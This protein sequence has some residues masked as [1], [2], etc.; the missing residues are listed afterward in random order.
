MTPAKPTGLKA[1]IAKTPIV[2]TWARIGKNLSA[3]NATLAA[4]GVAFYA[5]LSIFPAIACLLMIWGFFADVSDLGSSFSILQGTV[6]PPVYEIISEQ[7]MRIAGRDSDISLFA[8][9][10]SSVVALWSASKAINALLLAMQVMYNRKKKR[11]FLMQKLMALGFT[12]GGVVF[13]LA[14]I[15]LIG[16]IPQILEALRLG[17]LTEATILI[18]RWVLIIGLFFAGGVMFYKVSRRS[19][20]NIEHPK[21]NQVYPGALAAAVIWMTGSLIFSIYLSEFETYNETFGSLGAVAALLMW[22]WISA[23]ALL[24]G[25]EINTDYAGKKDR[26]RDAPVPG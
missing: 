3:K 24:I 1:L 9:L 5:F 10:A 16:V 13:V 21:R 22:F 20:N 12:L 6:P 19:Q 18:L 11:S 2:R 7:M 15:A 26:E 4:G 25:A 14:S 23:L 8:A 17:S